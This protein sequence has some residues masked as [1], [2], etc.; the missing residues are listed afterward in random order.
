MD[1]VSLLSEVL[2]LYIMID[3]TDKVLLLG[4]LREDYHLK[5]LFR[6]TLRANVL[7][8]IILAS[9]AV[10]GQIIL[11]DVFHIDVNALR[12]AGGIILFKIGAE[13]LE[14]GIAFTRQEESDLMSLATV[15]VAMPLIAGPAAITT[16]ITI[17]VKDG[18]LVSLAVTALAV[19]AVAVTMLFAL[20]FMKSVNKKLLSTIVRLMGLFI[21]AIGAQMAVEGFAAIFAST[22]HCGA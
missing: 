13:A 6:F 1:V 16:V 9:F 11:Q 4:L 18:V 7:G 21:M 5:D 12:L 8:F 20:R 2:L 14:G 3:P 10:A 19:L 22:V 17:A 15:P